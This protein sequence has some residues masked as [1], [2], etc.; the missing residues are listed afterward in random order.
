[1]IDTGACISIFKENTVE[2]YKQKFPES[3]TIHGITDIKIAIAE[4]TLLSFAVGNSHQVILGLDFVEHYESAIDSKSK[5]LVMNFKKI[6]IHK[7]IDKTQS[8]ITNPTL[9]K[10]KPQNNALSNI[11]SIESRV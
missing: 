1:M 5:E 4:S 8:Q 10:P 7:V 9:I 6:T 3:I 2:N 11:V